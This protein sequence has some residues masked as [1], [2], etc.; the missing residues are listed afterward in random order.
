MLFRSGLAQLFLGAPLL[1][2]V[3]ANDADANGLAVGHG[4]RKTGDRER[5][6]ELTEQG[7]ALVEKA[8][9]EDGFPRRHLEVPYRNASIMYQTLGRQEQAR[10]MADRAA[11]LQSKGDS[12]LQRR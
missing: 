7:I 8:V 9:Q 2:Y 11:E 1:G 10:K 3:R 12:G 5:G 6:L 4:D